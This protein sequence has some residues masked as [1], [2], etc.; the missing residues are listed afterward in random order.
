MTQKSIIIIG[1]GIGGLSAG[2]YA[3]MNGYRSQIFEMH[4]IP[5]GVCTGWERKGYT[6]DGCMH[7]LV[8]CMPGTRIHGMWEELGVMP[9]AVHYPDD[10]ICIEN[11]EGQRFTVFT[12]LDRLEAHMRELAPTDGKIIGEF[13][14]AA[15]RFSHFSMMDMLLAK[16]WEM[17]GA[18]PYMG[19]MGKWGKLTLEQVGARF[20]DPFLRRA[21]G[22][23]QYDFANMPAVIA[24]MFL[25]GCA[26]R[27]FGWPA[28]GSLE[29]ARSIAQRYT[30]L[31][32]EIHYRAKVQK[33]LVENDKAVGV[34]LSDGTEHRADVVIS[35]ADGRATI[36]DM[37]EGRYTTDLIHAFYNNPPKEQ[38]MAL[39]IS[40]GVARDFSAE[41]HMLV[42]WLPEPVEIAG[43]PRDRLDIESFAFAPETAP[44]GKTALQVVATTSYDYWKAFSPEAY[45]A[46]KARAAETVIACLDRRFPSL[47]GQMEVIDVA[48]P[49]TTERFTGSFMGYQAWAVPNQRMLDALMGKGLSKTLPGL[50]NFHMVGQWAGGLGLP[51]VAAMGKRVIAG[52]TKQNGRRFVTAKS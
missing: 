12:D 15:R 1:A 30:A 47:R 24:L 33:I 34:R 4:S 32:G 19:L 37:L 45:R 35:N 46:E 10:L 36:F 42:L 5:G 52:I 28:G 31:G 26:T 40:L 44:T 49:L 8:G 21:M 14:G 39:H 13:L 17:V 48:T 38:D 7:H 18:L 41:P 27:N 6:F 29:F 3:Q 25:S 2:C 20:S 9:R 51:N 11:T 50:S 43:Q 22:M 23:I 16:P